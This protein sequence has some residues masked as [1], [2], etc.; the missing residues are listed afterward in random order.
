MPCYPL[1]A[2]SVCSRFCFCL[3]FH[4]FCFLLRFFLLILLVSFF[5]LPCSHVLFS[6]FLAIVHIILLLFRLLSHFINSSDLFSFFFFFSRFVCFYLL[7]CAVCFFWPARVEAG[8]VGLAAPFPHPQASPEPLLPSPLER[9]EAFPTTFRGSP[10]TLPHLRGPGMFAYPL[11]TASRLSFSHRGDTLPAS[12]G[13]ASKITTS[14]P[15]C[16]M[17]WKTPRDHRAH[18]QPLW[19]FE[20]KATYLC[21]KRGVR[22]YQPLSFFFFL[23]SSGVR[24]ISANGSGTKCHHDACMWCMRACHVVSCL[25][26]LIYVC[27]ST[28]AGC[29]R[30]STFGANH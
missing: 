5:A 26:R 30:G 2:F 19:E 20:Y 21:N 1:R 25:A 12:P 7:P 18:C 14:Y 23:F 29:D 16:Y 11:C 28:R 24:G 9:F 3:L 17:T 27:A 8:A 6:F 10:D 4:Q 22:C 15:V 13:V